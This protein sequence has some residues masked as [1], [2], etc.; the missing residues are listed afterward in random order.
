MA[1]SLS[2]AA[3]RMSATAAAVATAMASGTTTAEA[4]GLALVLQA[5]SRRP[6]VF[7][8]VL[9]LAFSRQVS[10]TD[11]SPPAGTNQILGG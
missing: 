3:S 8:Q 7:D 2:T 9:A 5:L 1:I 6:D 4:Q 11:P 10:P